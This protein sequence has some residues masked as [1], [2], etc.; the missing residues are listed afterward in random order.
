MHTSNTFHS[1]GKCKA[2]ETDQLS[3]TVEIALKPSYPIFTEIPVDLS[4]FGRKKF[5]TIR[6]E[7]IG[8]IVDRFVI[9][10]LARERLRI[11]SGL[12]FMPQ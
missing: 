1:R 6:G 3:N 8:C 4:A 11:K 9:V 7:R 5:N 2:Q 10:C 12:D